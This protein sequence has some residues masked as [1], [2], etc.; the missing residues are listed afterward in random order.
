MKNIQ[1]KMKTKV[2]VAFIGVLTVSC[3]KKFEE[4]YENPNAVT[5]ID[6]SALFTKSV[7]SLFQ[8]TTDQA[9]SR[10]A[11]MYAHYYVAGSTWSAPDQFGD[12]FDDTYGGML[13]DGYTGSIRHIV[14]V[15]TLT[16]TDTTKNDTRNAMA[17]IVAVLA[18][19]KVT[20]AFGDV[21]YTEG[22]KGKSQNILQPKYDTQQSIYTDLITRLT[23]SIAVLKAADS[24]KAYPNSDPI[25]NND[26][27]KW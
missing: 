2:I 6:D 21:P 13:S 14:E 5:K 9:S 11:G 16:S 10:F 3:E 22:G 24:A 4:L 15:L 26:L 12:G 19:P 17:N 1:N 27:S 7:R 20:D 18:Y 25:F 23:S 8:S